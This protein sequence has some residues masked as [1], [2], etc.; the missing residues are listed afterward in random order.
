MSD[1]STH[2]FEKILKNIKHK[3]IKFVECDTI[4]SIE[5]NLNTKSIMFKSKYNQKKDGMI[6]IGED[7]GLIVVDISTSDNAVRSF[8]LKNQYDINWIDNIVGWFQQNYELEK[9]LI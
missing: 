2:D 3:I 7:K 9:S 8:I 5:S 1:F 4:K 6:I